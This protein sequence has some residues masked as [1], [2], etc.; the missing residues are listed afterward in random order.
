MDK[1]GTALTFVSLI[2]K[3]ILPDII[4]TIS[5]LPDIIMT[6]INSHEKTNMG[7]V[8]VECRCILNN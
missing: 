1:H 7:V 4:M 5:I 8:F 3:T 2:G 6:I